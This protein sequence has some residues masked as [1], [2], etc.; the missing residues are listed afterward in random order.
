MPSASVSMDRTFKDLYPG[1]GTRLK[2]WVV[3]LRK[4]LDWERETCPWIDNEAHRDNTGAECRNSGTAQWVHLE[5][6]DCCGECN[7]LAEVT[8]E[9]RASVRDWLAAREALP[10]MCTDRD[11]LS[12]EIEPDRAA[13]LQHPFLAVMGQLR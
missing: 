10:P 13:D 6:H 9:H 11:K 1:A 3:D 5:Q 2:Q 7:D 8:K 12:D 4:R